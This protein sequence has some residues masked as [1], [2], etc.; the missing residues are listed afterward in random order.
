MPAPGVR[1][2]RAADRRRVPWKNGAGATEEI[3]SDLDPVRGTPRWRISLA[4][5]G[6]DPSMFS[7]FDGMDRIF[8]VVGDHGVTLEWGTTS[9]LV[10]PWQPHAFDGAQAPRC[11]PAGATSALNVMVAASTAGVTVAPVNLG[12]RPLTSWPDEVTVLF[13]RSGTACAESHRAVA[14]DCIVVRHEEVALRGDGQAV[15]IRIRTP[16][17]HNHD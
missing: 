13:V 6:A 16:K 10:A 11:I 12:A 7:T 3:A 2:I 17:R 15:V 9:E 14:G 5:L 4:D 8:T 1:L